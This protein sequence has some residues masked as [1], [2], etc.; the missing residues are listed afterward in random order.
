MKIQLSIPWRRGCRALLT[1]LIVL[2]MLVPSA[3]RM[4]RAQSNP[5]PE[6]QFIEL[7]SE[8]WAVFEN[9][10]WGYTVN[11]PVD[12]QPRT[13]FVNVDDSPVYV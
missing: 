6:I 12:W 9:V 1:V 3:P 4:V 2:G 10:Q 13:V 8:E 11:H 7:L 5:L